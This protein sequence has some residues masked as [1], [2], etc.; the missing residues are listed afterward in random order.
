[1]ILTDV[2]ELAAWL[3]LLATP[4]IG[5][6]V[7]RQLLASFGTPQGVFEASSGQRRA[8]VDAGIADA[9]DAEPPRFPSLLAS[10]RAWLDGGPARDWVALG[11]PRYPQAL[12]QTADPPLLLYTQGRCELLNTPSLAIVGSRNPTP[13]GAENA[14]AFAEHLGRAGL[15]IVSGMALGIDGA[16]HAGTLAAGAPTIAVIG[17]GPDIV[18]P[19]AH[20]RP[21]WHPA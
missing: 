14:R 11:D 17:T 16:A 21:A 8:C 3:R 10:T 4:G 7:A 13:Q 20:R 1:M 19:R 5:R 12:L 15:T 6:G 18:Y 2:D 9:L